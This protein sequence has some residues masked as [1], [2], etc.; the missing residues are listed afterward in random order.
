MAYDIQFAYPQQIV[1]I[2]SVTTVEGA[3]E[4]TLLVVGKDFT[5]VSEVLLNDIASPSVVVSSKTS[6][7]AVVPKEV[8]G[9]SVVTVVIVSYQAV[10][11][12]RSVVS[13]QFGNTNRK[14]SGINRLVQLFL[15][16]LLTTPGSDIFSQNI[17][18]AALR[19]LGKTFSKDAAG[20]IVGDF[21][22]AVDNTAKQIIAMQAR[23]SRLPRDERL[24][25]A[26]VQS[27]RFDAAQTALVV[28]VELN[29]QAGTSATANLVL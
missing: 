4:P 16:V 28:T 19:N 1:D 21:I 12:E 26:Q 7:T 10:F 20:G 23:N 9:S 25:S 2:T 3:E 15:K 14:T 24:L 13:F 18:G 27:S 11:S 17:G 6:L 8:R 29:S 22:I 5:A